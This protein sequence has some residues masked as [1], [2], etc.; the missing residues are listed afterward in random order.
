MNIQQAVIAFVAAT[1][2]L[3]SPNLAQAMCGCM[4]P[5]RPQKPT[6]QQLVAQKILN[7]ASKVALIRDGLLTTLTMSND[8]STDYDEFGL[9][10]PV[11]T[12][13]QK[14]DVRVVEPTVFAALEEITNPRLI[15][16]WDPDPCPAEEEMMAERAMAPSVADAPSARSKG[17]RSAADY[18]VKVEAHYDVGEYSI[19]VLSAKEGAGAGLME[20]LNKFH[21]Q[22]PPEAVPVID[23][24]IKQGMRFFV[25][26]VNFRKLKGK[27]TTFLRPLQ[28]RYET[29]KFM[30]PVRLGTV[31]ADG[32][33]ELVVYALSAKGRI[34]ATNYRSMRMPSGH[35]LPLYVKGQFEQIYEQIFDAATK[36]ADMRAIFTEYVE[37]GSIDL[38][39]AERVG[40][41]W[42]KPSDADAFSYY[43]TT[44]LHFR[45]DAAH[46]P[47]DLVLQETADIEAFRVNYSLHHPADRVQ[48]EEG[49]K[50]L[51]TLPPRREK[52][53]EA[54]A[55]LT[56][57]DLKEIRA[58]M[59]LPPKSAIGPAQ[60]PTPPPAKKKGSF[61]DRLWGQ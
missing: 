50:Y 8:V 27:G 14:K 36:E 1:S 18:G 12:V 41:S 4:I 28:V 17:A 35:D 40:L 11:P 56:A 23:S 2:L 7:K 22:V 33:Q 47:E 25:A 59:G 46:F 57:G 31:N 21:Y 20:W 3:F 52:E 42:D 24:Y 45:Y 44:R 37:R 19:A 43:T 9:V 34:E 6:Q 30:L 61:W 55:M 16:N 32:P 29:P 38:T 15:E 53:A 51:A 54:L 10:V 48:C 58:K 60:P 49:Q 39:T 13:I 5:M 26:K